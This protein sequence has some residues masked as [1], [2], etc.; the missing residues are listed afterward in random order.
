MTDS[1]DRLFPQQNSLY[2]YTPISLE[3]YVS[4][5]SKGKRDR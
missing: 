1:T 5:V 4:P 3:I 2:I